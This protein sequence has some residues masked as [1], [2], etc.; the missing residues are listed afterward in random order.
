MQDNLGKKMRIIVDMT[1]DLITFEKTAKGK[2]MMVVVN[3]VVVVNEYKVEEKVQKWKHDD[4]SI[5]KDEGVK[6]NKKKNKKW[7]RKFGRWEDR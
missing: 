1:T 7:M 3:V 6:I 4:R 5:S 2:A